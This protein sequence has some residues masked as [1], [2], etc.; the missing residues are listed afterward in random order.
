MKRR[1]GSYATR[2]AATSAALAVTGVATVLVGNSW[3]Q[4]LVAAVL[5]FVLTQMAF[6]GHDAAHRQIFDSA[7]K[8]EWAARVLTGLVGG[9]S[10]GWWLSKHSRHHGAPNQLGK[11]PDIESEVLSFSPEVAHTRRGLAARFTAVQ[12]TLFLPLLLLEGLNLHYKGVQLLLRRDPGI[13]QVW[14]ERAFVGVRIA[15][16]LTLLAVLLPPGK[17]A[18]FLGIQLGVFGLCL[19]GAFAPNHVGMPIVAKGARVD[20]LH[21]QVAMSRNVS[22][23]WA[24]D[25]LMGGLNLQV[26]HHLFPAM[27]RANLRAVR[28]LVRAH[29]AEHGLV[30]TE[31]TLWSAYRQLLGYL[32]TVGVRAAEP[33]RCPLVATLRS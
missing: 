19:G 20:F 7:R 2:I 14:A 21:R 30:Y 27:P 4:L 22:G 17:A 8:N 18:A 10:Y 33:F 31:T 23:G 24:I 26:E 9:L 25:L 29:C 3:W 15:G 11:D 13:K 32:N 12:G 1:R 28:P 16:Y 5:G 6:L